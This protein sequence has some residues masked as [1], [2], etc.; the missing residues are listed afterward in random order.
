MRYA[1]LSCAALFAGFLML[2]A[3]AHAATEAR[4]DRQNFA[5]AQQAHHLDRPDLPAPGTLQRQVPVLER[6][7][8]LGESGLAID[9]RV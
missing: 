9:R 4:F 2:G 6:Q 5:S 3:M 8:R 1:K 7:K